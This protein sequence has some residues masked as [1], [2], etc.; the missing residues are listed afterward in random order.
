[1]KFRLLFLISFTHV[2]F[3]SQVSKCDYKY[4][5]MGDEYQVTNKINNLLDKYKADK[6]EE[7]KDLYKQGSESDLRE[8]AKQLANSRNF[9]EWE[10]ENVENT[11]DRLMIKNDMEYCKALAKGETKKSKHNEIEDKY[12]MLKKFLK[13][14]IEKA[15]VKQFGE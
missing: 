2:F 6:K 15:M 9:E 8:K 10:S 13:E 3:Y 12:D 5:E 1:M 4:I 11:C 7:T 14:E